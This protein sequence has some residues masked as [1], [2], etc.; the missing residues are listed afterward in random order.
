MKNKLAIISSQ[1]I[2][3]KGNKFEI[4]KVDD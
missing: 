4:E 1:Y 3:L 2:I